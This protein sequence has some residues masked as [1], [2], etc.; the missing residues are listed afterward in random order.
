MTSEVTAWMMLDVIPGHG[1]GLAPDSR[2][3]RVLCLYRY[4]FMPVYLLN[5]STDCLVKTVASQDV[6]CGRAATP[7]STPKLVISW[8]YLPTSP[9]ARADAG[10]P[11]TVCAWMNSESSVLSRENIQLLH[12]DH[13]WLRPQ[14]DMQF[15]APSVVTATCTKNDVICRDIWEY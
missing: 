2:E 3:L 10:A 5:R 8:E 6:P 4:V 1:S 7:I 12:L 15:T 13:I 14:P 9:P 11:R